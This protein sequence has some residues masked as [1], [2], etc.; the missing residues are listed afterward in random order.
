MN[1]IIIKY[2][3]ELFEKLQRCGSSAVVEGESIKFN[4]LEAVYLTE[5]GVIQL[6]AKELS[7]S[8]KKK[9]F[10]EKYLVFRHFFDHGYPVRVSLDTDEYLRVYRKGVKVGEDRTQYLVKIT[11]E[12]ESIKDVEEFLSFVGKFRKE[13][14]LAVVEKEKIRFI[15]FG[16]L[17]F[18]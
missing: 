3:Q 1:S 4:P 7:K 12:K 14:I 2:S 9:G 16:R 15:K 17:T 11:N 18:D 6:P 10:K 5:K 13:P 8:T